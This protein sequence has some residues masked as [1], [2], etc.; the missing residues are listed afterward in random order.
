MVHDRYAITNAA[1]GREPHL[2]VSDDVSTLHAEHLLL[3]P[4]Q[5]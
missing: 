1:D 4:E 2:D 3:P 5:S